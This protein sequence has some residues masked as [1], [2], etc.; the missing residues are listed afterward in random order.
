[1]PRFRAAP[2]HCERSV[3]AGN[4]SIPQTKIPWVTPQ[5][6]YVSDLHRR[7]A[8]IGKARRG[9]GSSLNHG[10]GTVDPCTQDRGSHSRDPGVRAGSWYRPTRLLD[11]VERA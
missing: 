7:Y 10:S 2:A 6:T 5:L 1:M 9:I 4:V 11:C 8:T 3:R